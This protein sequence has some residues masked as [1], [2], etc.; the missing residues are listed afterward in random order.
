MTAPGNLV[1]GS[2]KLKFHG[3]LLILLLYPGNS[4]VLP[5]CLIFPASRPAYNYDYTASITV[6][7]QDFKHPQ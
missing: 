4:M 5:L 6:N 1:G 2:Y 7:M 3:L